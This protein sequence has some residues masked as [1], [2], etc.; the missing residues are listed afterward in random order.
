[1]SEMFS[2]HRALLDGALTALKDRGFWSPFPEVPSGKIYG[3][4]ARADGEAAF[5]ALRGKPFDLL[6]HPE[7]ARVGAEVSPFG[8]DLAIAYP[9]ASPAALTAAA[10]AAAPALAA[11]GAEARVGACL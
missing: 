7:S 10:A 8:P 11:A 9:A 3:E 6:S 2:R 5:A 1:M 4:T